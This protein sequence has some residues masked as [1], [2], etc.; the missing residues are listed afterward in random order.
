MLLLLYSSLLSYM[1]FFTLCVA[2][3]SNKILDDQNKSKF[4]RNIFPK[5]FVFGGI[6][7]SIALI[8]SFILKD[9]WS[10]I[11][12]FIIALGFIINLFIIMPK[13]NYISD[14]NNLEEKK[15]K[16]SFRNWHLSSVFIYLV[17]II[18]AVIG[19]ILNI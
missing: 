11:I 3:V 5:N 6:I 14:N 15:K 9:H 4:L 7:A 2:P 8:F 13:I 10:I 18:M 17:Q 1:L 16:K 19:I 12:S